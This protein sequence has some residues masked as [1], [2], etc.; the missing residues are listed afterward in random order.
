MPYLD[1]PR[2]KVHPKPER[3]MVDFVV[4]GIII[5]SLIY[6]IFFVDHYIRNTVMPVMLVSWIIIIAIFLLAISAMAVFAK[7][8]NY[9]YILYSDRIEF[10]EN[11]IKTIYYKNVVDA[12]P[13][14]NKLDHW[15]RTFTLEI[16]MNDGQ[17]ATIKNLP[18][19]NQFLFLFQKLLKQ[20]MT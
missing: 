12:R 1:V 15:F 13:S 8:H 4:T 10:H 19:N 9:A 14:W 6:I 7:Y 20:E 16:I 11:K 2:Y 5:A 17:K 18:D 3:Y